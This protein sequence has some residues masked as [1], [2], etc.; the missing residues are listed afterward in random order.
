MYLQC[1]TMGPASGGLQALTLRMKARMGVGYSG[2]PWSGHTINWNCLTSLFSLE[3]P[4]YTHIHKH[5]SD[6]R[7]PQVIQNLIYSV[8]KECSVYLVHSKGSD[9][10]CS[11]L[12]CVQQRDLNHA[13][14]LCPPTRPVLIT[15]NLQQK[16][17][18]IW[19]VHVC[20]FVY[21]CSCFY[22]LSTFPPAGS[23]W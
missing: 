23:S 8:I 6:S 7:W 2:T 4:C 18:V 9:T 16:S 12:H 15:L 13:I 14:C 21:I 17:L 22:L 1:T 20:A 10:V 11:K 19:F 3:P 5:R